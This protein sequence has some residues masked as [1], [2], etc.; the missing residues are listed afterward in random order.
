MRRLREAGV[1]LGIALG[2]LAVGVACAA[3]SWLLLRLGEGFWR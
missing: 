2:L 1:E 3:G